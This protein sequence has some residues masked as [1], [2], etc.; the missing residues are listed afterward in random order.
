MATGPW[1]VYAALSGAA[2]VDMVD[3]HLYA[4]A[5][6]QENIRPEWSPCCPS[7]PRDVLD[8]VHDQHY[9]L[10]V[11]NLP[12]TPGRRLIVDPPHQP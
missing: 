2:H 11:S 4:V 10:V 12:F 9:D 5:C 8:W 6:A 3:N 1:V 7:F